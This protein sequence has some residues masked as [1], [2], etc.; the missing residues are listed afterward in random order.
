MSH[1]LEHLHSPEGVLQRLRGVLESKSVIVVALPNVVWWQQR[2]HFLLGRWR[3]KASGILD[4]THFRFFDLRSSRELLEQAG[5]EIIR[6]RYDGAY[7]ITGQLRRLLD[8]FA[9]LMNNLLCKLAP[10]LF[11]SH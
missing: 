10:G 6:V 7:V 1:I 5:Y 8:P 2:I 4:R 11:A 9:T 3:Y